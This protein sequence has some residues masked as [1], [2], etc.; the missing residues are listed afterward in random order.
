MANAVIYAR[1]SSAGQREESIEDQVRVCRQAARRD[2]AEVVA[3]YHDDATTGRTADGRAA[4]LRMV[5]DAR[6]G[7]FSATL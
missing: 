5:A 7:A 2:G 4:F 3:V 6:R 1:Y